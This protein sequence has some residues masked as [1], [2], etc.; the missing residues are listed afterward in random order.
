[1]GA[2]DAAAVLIR[3]A[4]A[5]DLGDII[6]L[7]AEVTGIEKTDYW[8]ELFQRYGASRTR[9]RF[10]VLTTEGRTSHTTTATASGRA[11]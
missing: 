5:S 2:S 6:A 10:T 1:M 8:Y 7:D 3:S 9:Q 11:R 4:Q